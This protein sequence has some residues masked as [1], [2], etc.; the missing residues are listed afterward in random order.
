MKQNLKYFIVFDKFV[1]KGKYRN[2]HP[3]TAITESGMSIFFC[4][5]NS[6]S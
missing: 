4:L 2:L 3:I 5:S 6:S 1:Y